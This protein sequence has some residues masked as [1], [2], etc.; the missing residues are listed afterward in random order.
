M[1]FPVNDIE[2]V[3]FYVMGSEDHTRNSN[4]NIISK[5]LFNNDIPIDN[6]VYSLKMGTTSNSYRCKTCL[7]SRDKCPGHFG[8][9]L[10]NYPVT[11]TLF[12]NEI[13]KW[14]RIVCHNCGNIIN[15]LPDDDISIKKVALLSKNTV[16]KVCN[17]KH[18][19]I[20]KD[21]KEPLFLI[22]RDS[23]GI[24][25]KLYNDDIEKIFSRI[26]KETVLKL[27]KSENYHPSKFILR[28]I[29]ALP[30][31]DRPDVR[32]M[33]GGGRANNNDTTTLIK[34]IVNHNENIPV[35]LNENDKISSD[36]L[37]NLLEITHYSMVKDTPNSYSSSKL[38]GINGQVLTSISTRLRGKTGRIRGNL[39][40]KRIQYAARSVI[41]G[42]N[43]I[44]IDEA[45]I[46]ISIAKVLQ[47]P[48]TVTKFN[49]DRLMVYFLNKN[50]AYPGCTNIIKYD[51]PTKLCNVSITKNDIVLECGDI[52]FRDLI[53][54]DIIALN[55][56]P[57]LLDTA[58]SGHRV[59]ILPNGDTIRISVNVAD[60][61]YGGDFDGDTMAI[62][63]PHSIITRN[64]C[65]KLCSIQKRFISYQNRSP[66]M[67]I[68][69]DPLIGVF[70]LT[71]QS[72]RINKY[73]AMWLLSQVEYGSYLHRF[74]SIL[75]NMS[76]ID[77]I[78]LL[79]PE[80]NYSKK[81][82]F[83]KPEYSG[84]IQYDKNETHVKIE[85]GKIISGRL[86]K[87]SVGQGVNDSIFHVVYNEYG[88][89]VS[90]DL[91]YNIQQVATNYLLTRGY[92][93][94]YDDIAIKKDIL[95]K[96]N[97]I[98]SSILHD[99]KNLTN[100][101]R[102]GLIT[103]PI[104][105]TT[106]EYYEQEQISILSPGDDFTEVVMSGLDHEKNNLYKLVA[107]GTKG[108]PTNILQI[109]SSIGQLSIKGNRMPKTF[110]LG[111][112]IPY[113]NRFHDNPEAVGFIPESFV[114]GVSS[115]SSISQYVYARNGISI[116]ALSTGVTGYHNRKCNKTLESIIIDN[117]RRAVKY[118]FILQQLYGDDGIDIRKVAYVDFS[119]LLTS[120][121]EFKSRY[122]IEL[123]NIN[124][125]NKL[126]L[127]EERKQLYIDREFYRSGFK[128]IEEY[129]IN[130][131]I[132]S[133]QQV[134]PVNISKIID[135]IIY[136][137]SNYISQINTPITPI[138]WK[139]KIDELKERL[140]YCHYN[141]IQYKKRMHIPEHILKSFSLL[142]I[143]I[144][145]SMNYKKLYDLKFDIKL[146]NLLIET[147]CN[148]FK[149]SL[150]H[151]GGSV[152]MIASECTSASMTQGMLDSI[153]AVGTSN[154]NFLTRIKEIYG[155]KGTS[156][157]SSPSMDI[158]IKSEYSNDLTKIQ[159]VANNIEMMELKKFVIKSQIFFENYKE[160]KHPDYIHEIKDLFEPYE[161][162][163]VNQNIPYN[164]IKWC[165]RL[166]LN[167]EILI[168]KNM[169]VSL[170]YRKLREQH[171][172]LYIIYTDDNSENIIFRIYMQNT[173][174]KKVSNVNEYTI[175][176]YVHTKLLSTII[177]GVDGIISAVVQKSF[178]PRS[179]IQEDGSIKIDRV[180]IIKTSGTNLN[181]IVNNKFIDVTR[182]SSNSIIEIYEMYGIHAAKVKLIQFLRELSGLDINIKHYKLIADS[183]TFN[184]YISNIEKSGL[185]ESNP[186][187][188]LLSMS[189]SHPIQKMTECAINNETSVVLTN[190]SSSLLMGTTPNI[191]SNYNSI[192]MN[193]EFIKN[194]IVDVENLID[195]L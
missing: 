41:S 93:M 51:E 22:T 14:L 195:N 107:S 17:T 182:T 58:I 73:N 140:P 109:S 113:F 96:I 119:M 83:Y 4:I 95:K 186:N 166:E 163:N 129:S 150:V 147:I 2:S 71:K 165:I 108:K 102:Q 106:D 62:Y 40:G 100:K 132:L 8:S 116:K 9:V 194:N 5:D 35:I 42:D 92:T 66:A 177:R 79:L 123:S 97:N 39:E 55:R 172:L 161:K 191:G 52:L 175:R 90:M 27:D 34:N 70:E 15:K 65:A 158:F 192:V 190:L 85:R 110:S 80:I 176:D 44:K 64:E 46:P 56:A 12:K 11:N 68:Y 38:A 180:H 153:H 78:S 154:T 149:L 173:L 23:E 53:D 37:L 127:L 61:M 115:L 72:T 131:N 89:K 122:E 156:Q 157:L 74:K 98:T 30:N 124:D 32:K 114:T 36:S 179:I 171:P 99:S 178:V 105:M 3:E 67:G 48:E 49:I 43:N 193:E 28:T 120:D 146:V 134:L 167:H 143:S 31:T 126:I 168:E 20:M 54:G 183:L 112:S 164:L 144:N 60:T 170:I 145:V 117:L 104:G 77:I 103:P 133:G 137:H 75:E 155:A 181:D 69:H 26:T 121:L 152:G 87:K 33:Q 125:T 94:T 47:I 7:N 162:H 84:F 82:N 101:L 25:K 118:D 151:Y 135:N 169:Q 130:D 141:E 10:L 148:T 86:D 63:L 189:Y 187:N 142:Y 21:I 128:R 59:R 185:E 29:P 50:V 13:L 136:N 91:L 160:I 139:Q 76:G 159:E 88:S 111:R 1:S 18:P 174:F 81:S 19:H 57:S 138:E 188:A 24:E 184:G 6:G 45:G 16:C